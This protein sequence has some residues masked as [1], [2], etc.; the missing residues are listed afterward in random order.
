ME[1]WPH[2]CCFIYIMCIVY[3]QFKWGNVLNCFRFYRFWSINPVLESDIKRSW[4]CQNESDSIYF[5][6]VI[7]LHRLNTYVLYS[8]V[9]LFEYTIP[10]HNPGLFTLTNTIH[11]PRHQ[12]WWN[13][14]WHLPSTAYH[15]HSLEMC[16]M[17]QLRPLHNLLPWRQASPETPVLQDHHPG[18][19][20]V[21]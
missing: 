15:R 21:S 8:L 10:W 9:K 11:P 12:A 2:P 14:V 16:W 1:L 18:Q 4:I 13:H 19:W 20:E 6:S 5:T 7:L 3:P 17:H